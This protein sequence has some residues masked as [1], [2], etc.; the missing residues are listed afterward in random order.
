MVLDAY[1]SDAVP[2]HLLTKEA[3]ELYRTKLT[4]G[5]VLLFHVSNRRLEIDRVLGALVGEGQMV[6]LIQD[7][8]PDKNSPKHTARSHWVV[9]A[10]QAADLSMLEGSGDWQVLPAGNLRPWTDDFSNII[11]VVR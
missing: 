11:H 8:K 4:P 2:V 10:E 9:V 1:S 3:L 6:A 5:G 7:H